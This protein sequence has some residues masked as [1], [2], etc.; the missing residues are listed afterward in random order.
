[1]S[2]IQYLSFEQLQ[3]QIDVSFWLKFTGKKLDE[4]KLEVPPQ[5]LRAYISMPMNTT[6]ASSLVLD[7]DSFINDQQAQEK[8]TTTGGIIDFQLPG[9]FLHFNTIEEYNAFQ[10]SEVV[11][12]KELQEKYG[13]PDLQG[14]IHS[15]YFVMACFGDLKNYD[16][17]Y[18]IGLVQ[19][20]EKFQTLK[21]KKLS[22][23]VDQATLQALK[24][25]INLNLS[26]TEGNFYP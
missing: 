3:T 15:N 24:E 12:N 2:N 16:Y 11:D 5:D 17:H 18:R 1:M 14:L 19:G 21:G 6:V 20:T 22:K 26:K 25:Q 10:F 4:W 13:L 9:K 23:Q 7:G 8:Q